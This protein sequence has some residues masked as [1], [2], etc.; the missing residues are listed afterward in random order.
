MSIRLKLQLSF[1]SLAALAAITALIA[2]KINWDIRLDVAQISHAS[3]EKHTAADA[4]QDALTDLRLYLEERLS[5][6]YEEATEKSRIDGAINRTLSEFEHSFLN[7]RQAAL[8]SVDLAKADGE[9]YE[10]KDALQGLIAL[11]EMKVKFL[12][13][14]EQIGQA[15]RAS[16]VELAPRVLLATY[17]EL[18][19]MVQNYMESGK[20]ELVKEIH[21][22]EDST[23]RANRILIE[24]FLIILGVSVV[25]AWFTTRSLTR[26]ISLLSK[27]ALEIGQGRLSTVIDLHSRDE[28]GLLAQTFNRMTVELRSTMVSKDYVD[29][30]LKAMGSTLIV[31]EAD[32]RIRLANQSAL[33]L[34]GYSANEL[35]GRPLSCLLG[36]IADQAASLMD[37]LALT[38]AVS[39]IEVDYR[40]KEGNII[41]MALSASAL[42]EGGTIT[43]LIYVAEDI[44]RRKQADAKLERLHKEL[45]GASRQAGMAEV[46]TSV[47]H[48]V[49]N[50]L[51]SV[52]VSALLVANKVNHS[53]LSNLVKVNSLLRAH[54]AD[55][56][57]FLINDSQGRQ[58]PAYLHTLADHLAGEHQVILK[59]LES[60]RKNIE[61]IKEI[62]A[63]QQDYSKVYGVAET[64]PVVDLVEDALRMNAGAFVRHDVEL[65][66]D[67]QAHPTITVEKHKLLQILVNL[68]RNA[69]YACDES[70]RKDKQMKIRVTQGDGRVQ[71]AVID[72]GIGIPA[73]NLQQIF[74]HGFTTRKT[75]HG[76]GLHS[77]ALAAQDLGGTLT[78]HS[79]GQ[80]QGATFI[81]E[82]PLNP[83]RPTA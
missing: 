54:E 37:Q 79:D 31:T 26:P 22:V 6:Q 39:D 73:A 30:I 75:G 62:V 64:Q 15:S 65:V 33:R 56:A 36:K 74:A 44:S 76:Y 78:A 10:I 69:K 77:G 46:A 25:L 1:A 7:L 72:N 28:F 12:H 70:G 11:E 45:L 53:K 61:H 2:A 60:L 27:A 49:G 81:L 42:R 67:Y 47:L 83:P 66:R 23:N 18:R 3:I 43:D 48:N 5:G 38:G 4:M 16:P 55:F 71:I 9:E 8:K 20:Q 13:L 40:T 59:E 41:P 34:L 17:D 82:L 24:S 35:I 50:V 51:N 80:N 29:S 58:I 52:N 57:S 14:K 68:M 32:G 21:S 19:T 63:M